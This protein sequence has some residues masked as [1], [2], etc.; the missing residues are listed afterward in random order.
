MAPSAAGLGTM[1]SA[2]VEAGRGASAP[3]GVDRLTLGQNQSPPLVLTMF[4]GGVDR[5]WEDDN[6]TKEEELVA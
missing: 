2:A 4:G 1:A 3:A 6:E 5:E